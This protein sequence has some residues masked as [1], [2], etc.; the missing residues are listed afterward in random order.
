[1][2]L[3]YSFFRDVLK[4]VIIHREEFKSKYELWLLTKE[5]HTLKKCLNLGIARKG[6]GAGLCCVLKIG[7][8]QDFCQ[9]VW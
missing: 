6:G 2:Y 8:I 7:G 5:A 3:Q 4:R 1:M 9:Y